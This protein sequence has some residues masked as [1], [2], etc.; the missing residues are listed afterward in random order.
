MLIQTSSLKNVSLILLGFSMLL[1][2]TGCKKDSDDPYVCATCSTTPQALAANNTS[3]KG[4]YKGIMIGSTGT[5]K[6]DVMNSG[7]TITAVLVVDA[8]TINLTSSVTW[9][10]GVAYVAPFTGTF[11]GAPISV[12][13][14]INSTG[15][16][17]S[18]TASNIP[19][20][21]NSTFTIVKETST[22]LIECFEGTYHTTLPEDGTFNIIVVRS[23]SIWG[24][25]AR[26]NGTTTTTSAGGTITTDSKLKETNGTV[27]G[28]LTADE[29]NGSFQDGGGK[30]VTITGKRTL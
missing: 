28:T 25:A 11:N 24:A 1:L 20:H 14:S 10:A 5:I 3:S 26:K 4:I 15:G 13:L 21:P 16:S 9:Q 2:A 30:T 29:I 18:V 8:V 22:T 12:T 17:P 27:M 7:T 23:A 19:G 6:F